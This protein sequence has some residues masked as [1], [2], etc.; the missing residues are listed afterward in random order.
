MFPLPCSRR[1]FL[2]GSAAAAV[3]CAFEFGT[4]RAGA[5]E[6]LSLFAFVPVLERPQAFQDALVLALPG[7]EVT[8]FGR[9]VDFKSSMQGRA[10]DAALALGVSLEAAGVP[11]HLR[12]YAAGSA[13][14]EY[15]VLAKQGS[16]NTTLG[17]TDVVGRTALP[18]MVTRLLGLSEAPAL[19]RVLKP[20]D[21]LPLLQLD[22]AGG[23][24]IPARHV[25]ALRRTTELSLYVRRYSGAQL[26][27]AALHFSQRPGTR[28]TLLRNSLEVLP[29][30][31]GST[32][33]IDQWK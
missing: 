9:F 6:S 8:V 28:E 11:I 16:Q 30:V 14:E 2:R 25:V 33:G 20:A 24:I 26:S 22:V 31:M 19:Q 7:V 5:R 32:L 1:T 15:V 4:R 12:G 17:V 10:P 21:L 29:R 27:R 23:V 13:T 3:G 18:A